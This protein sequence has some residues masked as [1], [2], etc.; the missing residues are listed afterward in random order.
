MREEEESGPMKPTLRGDAGKLAF[1]KVSAR[2]ASSSKREE[3]EADEP[4]HLDEAEIV[5][6]S[7]SDYESDDEDDAEPR[8]R[9]A[10]SDDES[11][12]DSSVPGDVVIV[13]AVDEPEIDDEKISAVRASIRDKLK[14]RQSA[15]AV[16]E[17]LP[18]DSAEVPKA[19]RGLYSD[20]DE[21][22]EDH[23]EERGAIAAKPEMVGKSRSAGV[24]RRD[25]LSSSSMSG[26]EVDSDEE[27][28]EEP[29]MM[30]IFRPKVKCYLYCVAR[31]RAQAIPVHP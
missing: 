13:N 29:L 11:D 17:A 10:D 14:A 24:G 16:V 15:A 23:D 2:P 6:L 19:R 27:S 30:P 26:S 1:G 9:R 22:L 4:R 25:S 8:R 28:E 7:S 20:E 5:Q 12:S 31:T 3:T 21:E 18:F